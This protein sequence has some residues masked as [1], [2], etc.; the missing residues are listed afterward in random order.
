MI[1]FIFYFDILLFPVSCFIIGVHSYEILMTL[2][3]KDELSVS[4]QMVSDC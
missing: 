3:N 4:S 1:V 2:H